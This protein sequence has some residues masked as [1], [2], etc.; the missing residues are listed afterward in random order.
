LRLFADIARGMCPL[1]AAEHFINRG[2]MIGAS[3]ELGI[4][5]HRGL[6][7][8]K[9]ERLLPINRDWRDA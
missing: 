1:L 9:G 6:F 8:G 3:P 2:R 7:L 4:A 5:T